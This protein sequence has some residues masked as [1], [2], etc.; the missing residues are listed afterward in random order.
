MNSPTDARGRILHTFT[1][2][3]AA[4]RAELDDRNNYDTVKVTL[5]DEEPNKIL[6]RF[7][8]AEDSED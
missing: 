5:Y 6:L 3:M 4:F 2:S 7:H 8:T 1:M